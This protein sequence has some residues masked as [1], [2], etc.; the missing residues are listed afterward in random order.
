MTIDEIVLAD[1]PEAWDALGFEVTGDRAQIGSVW[2]RFTGKRAGAGI[3]S[4]S[5][6]GLLDVRLDG[7]PTNA[8]TRPPPR[9]AVTQPNGVLAIDHV[10]AVSPRLERSIEALRAAGL[11]LRRVRDQP[12]PAG[13]PRQAFFRLGQEILEVVQEPE[14]VVERMAGSDRPLAFWGIALRVR[15]LPETVAAL[16]GHSGEMRP[17]IQ[18]GRSISS[19]RRSAGLAIPVALMS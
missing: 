12:T 10:V 17:A 4:W 19:I 3:V 18:P 14:E 15:D 9:A 2:L 16:S 5:L 11:D 7:L 1:D 13:A 6:R 8:S